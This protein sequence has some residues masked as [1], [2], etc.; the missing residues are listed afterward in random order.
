M[1]GTGA[2]SL[3]G[4]QIIYGGSLADTSTFVDSTVSAGKLVIVDAS[5]GA[6]AGRNLFTAL[7]S[8]QR[9]SGAAGVALINLDEFPPQALQTLAQPRQS[10]KSDQ[11]APASPSFLFISRNAAGRLLGKS[12]D[13]VKPGALGGTVTSA[14]RILEAPIKYPARNVVAMIEGSDPKL[15]TEFIAIGAHNDHIGFNNRPVA[16]DSLYVL[17]HLFRKQG[18]DDR[19]PQPT[20]EQFAQINSTLAE[21]RKT[22]GGTSARLDSIYNGADDDG[23]GQGQRARDRAVLRGEESEAEALAPLRLARR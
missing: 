7:R 10:L 16:H 8:L 11:L 19:P 12:I 20:P 23:S 5:G 2:R 15:R 22:N 3:S 4:V 14:P 21:I 1:Q 6:V 9:F 17:N 13:S 18:A